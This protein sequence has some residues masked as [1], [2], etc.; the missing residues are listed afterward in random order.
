MAIHP[1]EEDSMRDVIRQKLSDETGM[2][3]DFLS[4]R[5]ALRPDLI[6]VCADVNEL[7]LTPF[8]S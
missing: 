3:P 6:Q 8:Y 7:A 4:T 2:E 5:V 1:Y